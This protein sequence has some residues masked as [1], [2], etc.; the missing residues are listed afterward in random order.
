[1]GGFRAKIG[2]PDGV[3]PVDLPDIVSFDS[4]Q[5]SMMEKRTVFRMYC[6]KFQVVQLE[7]GGGCSCPIWSTISQ[8]PLNPWTFESRVGI[9]K[10]FVRE[11]SYSQLPPDVQETIKNKGDQ[12]SS[13]E[14]LSLDT[15][16]ATLCSIP[17]IEGVA[18][19]STLGENLERDFS[20]KYFD[21][22]NR[23]GQPLLGINVVDG[24]GDP[25]TFS[26]THVQLRVD[27]YVNE[28]GRP[29]QDFKVEEAGASTLSYLCATGSEFPH[30]REF[31]SLY[32]MVCVVLR[33][34]SLIDRAQPRLRME[35]ARCPT[36]RTE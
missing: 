35:L 12:A 17:T 1:M 7:P 11:E 20:E 22:L 27:P 3:T 4:S 33:N 16:V 14:Q 6:S 34:R 21:T 36:A 9:T 2:L 29:V 18:A 28:F 23:N 15:F 8:D 26:P 25:A 5:I 19:T 30:K 10:W 13:V 24:V 32:T 31:S